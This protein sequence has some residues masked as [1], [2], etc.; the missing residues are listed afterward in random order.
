[1]GGIAKSA[2]RFAALFM[3]VL[4]GSLAV[5]LTNGFVGEFLLLLGVWQY[6]PW[7][8]AVA[9]LTIIFGAVYLLR[10]FGLSMFGPTTAQTEGFQD[11]RHAELAVLGVLAIWVLVLGFFPQL[12]LGLTDSSV[13]RILSAVQF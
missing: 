5:P 4:L 9:G 11:V 13:D 12:I 7:V 10:A 2:P 3:I 8:G 1:M 6:N